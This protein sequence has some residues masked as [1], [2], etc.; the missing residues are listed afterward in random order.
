VRAVIVRALV[1]GHFLLMLPSKE[2]QPTIRAE[3]LRL[4]TGSE[5]LLH[6]EQKGTDLTEDLGTFHTVVEIEIDAWR[7]AA[8]ADD[9]DRNQR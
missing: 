3:E 8:W 9:V 4:F 2:S 1:D 7:P 5:S 6:L